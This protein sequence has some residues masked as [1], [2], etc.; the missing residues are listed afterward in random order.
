MSKSTIL[1]LLI[2]LGLFC[3]TSRA[4]VTIYKQETK[5]GIHS[6]VLTYAVSSFWLAKATRKT[7]GRDTG[8][9]S[10]SVEPTDGTRYP[11]TGHYKTIS[12]PDFTIIDSPES[13]KRLSMGIPG[14][15]RKVTNLRVG[16]RSFDYESDHFSKVPE[17]EALAFVPLFISESRAT[18][19]LEGQSLSVN[20]VGFTDAWNYCTEFIGFDPLL[21]EL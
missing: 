13:G 19:V 14:R 16:S 6:Y 17:N 21:D 18:W 15:M 11:R 7:T 1:V 4:D 9:K 8:Y 12:G 3:A 10:C 5:K 2:A 20:L